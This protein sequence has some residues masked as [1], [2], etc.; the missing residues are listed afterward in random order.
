MYIYVKSNDVSARSLGNKKNPNY[1]GF[2]PLVYTVTA[3]CVLIHWRPFPFILNNI[4]M[5]MH[6]YVYFHIR[7]CLRKSDDRI[8]F[9]F[10]SLLSP[11]S[12][13]TFGLKRCK[14]VS[15]DMLDW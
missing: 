4:C 7:L 2:K 5:F 8:L 12:K 15:P 11:F 1:S 6:K 14:I 9:L 3:K 13:L 10:F